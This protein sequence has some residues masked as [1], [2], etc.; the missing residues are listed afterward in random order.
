MTRARAPRRHRAHILVDLWRF[1]SQQKLW[2]MI[3]LIVVLMALGA[4]VIIG[5]QSA[6]A[7]FIYVLF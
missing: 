2:W 1:Y 7:P 5:Q 3:P 4:L 6:L